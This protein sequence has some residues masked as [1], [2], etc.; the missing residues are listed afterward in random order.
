MATNVNII[1]DWAGHVCIELFAGH[2]RQP[3]REFSHVG[4]K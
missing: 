1:T 2:D 4:L 3:D